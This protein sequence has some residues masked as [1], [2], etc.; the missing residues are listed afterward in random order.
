MLDAREALALERLVADGE[1]FVD[2]QDVRIDMDRHGEREPDVHAARIDLDRLVDE[3]A[4]VGECRDRIEARFDLGPGQS[5]HGAVEEHVFA[6]AELG[7][8]TCA[9]LEQRGDASA[10]I[11]HAARRRENAAD[12]LQQGRLAGAVA[13]DQADRLAVADI[14]IDVVQRMELAMPGAPARTE[15]RFEQA[16]VRAFVDRERLRHAA[17]MDRERVRGHRRIQP[18]WHETRRGTDT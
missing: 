7:V 3:V 2:H 10:H 15:Q 18:A 5:Q 13:A 6:A 9:E 8:E 14:Q 4:D 1:C 12:D 17:Q 16:V 11:D